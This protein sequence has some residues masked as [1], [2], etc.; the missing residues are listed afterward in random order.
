MIVDLE[1]SGIGLIRRIFADPAGA[2]NRQEGALRA[3]RSFSAVAQA[4][5]ILG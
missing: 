2:C 4:D 1:R 5:R 3:R